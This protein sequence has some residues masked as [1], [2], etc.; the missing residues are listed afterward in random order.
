MFVSYIFL[1][2][3]TVIAVLHFKHL[4]LVN[5]IVSSS[6]NGGGGGGGGGSGGGGCGGSILCQ[7]D[8]HGQ[9]IET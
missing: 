9:N 4:S 2:F 8:V 1:N 5:T 6:C 3:I 7:D